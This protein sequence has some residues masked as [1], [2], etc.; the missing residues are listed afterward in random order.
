M[1]MLMLRR[2]LITLFYVVLLL[3]VL[4]VFTCATDNYD[5]IFDSIG[6]E[7]I[8]ESLSDETQEYFN[9]LD[10]HKID[11]NSVFNINASK[12]FDLAKKMI[13][14]AVESPMKSLVR[15][16]AVII[17]IA[18][19]ECFISDN[20]QIRTISELVASLL[21]IFSIIEPVTTAVSSAVASVSLT[22]KFMICLIPVLTAVV[23]ASGNPLLAISFQSISFFGAQ[24]IS[25]I[26]QKFIVPLV[27]VIFVLD[28]TTNIMPTYKIGG[29]T[30][31]LKKS[32]TVVLSFGSTIYVS[33]LGLKGA[34]ANAAD[35]L[36]TKSIKL[37]ISSAV[38]VVGGALSEAYGSVV[39]SMVLVKSTVAVFALC[40]VALIN[41]P[42][43]IQLLFW[44][45]SLRLGAVIA[46]LFDQQGVTCL[47]KSLSSTIT[48][49]NVVV[50]FTAVL[51]A[52]STTLLLVIKAG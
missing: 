48:L 3:N 31:F 10:I 44:G 38:P 51:F 6:T 47:L 32:V 24:I 41:L 40:A 35:S 20:Q 9:D 25:L 46:D 5:S 7:D 52:V 27:G 43:C 11:F 34:L 26:A 18:V 12:V 39:G 33:F 21:C 15:M 29:L 23:S 8:F 19:C 16:I 1:I 37:V 45:L 42:S 4:T 28:I 14:G 2:I 17:L 13:T 36:S 22:E 49:L 50:L 30:D